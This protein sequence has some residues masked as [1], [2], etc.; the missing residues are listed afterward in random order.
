ML[1][2]FCIAYR[3]WHKGLQTVGIPQAFSLPL[4]EKDPQSLNPALLSL[5]FSSCQH[6]SPQPTVLRGAPPSGMLPWSGFLQ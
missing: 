2:L 3:V 4:R 1:S 5:S 6:H